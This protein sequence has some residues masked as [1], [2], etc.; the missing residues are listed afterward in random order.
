MKTVIVAAP[1]GAG[2]SR[3]APLLL[4]QLGLSRV[5][6]DWWPSEAALQPDALHLTNAH[7][8]DA[9]QALANR[10]PGAILT[11]GRVAGFEYWAAHA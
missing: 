3:A 7:P 4:E 1:Q 10:F 8:D 11:H 9:R 2:K 5:V 6:D